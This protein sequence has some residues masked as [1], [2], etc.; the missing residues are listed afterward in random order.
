MENVTF[1]N[2][3]YD[4]GR[5]NISVVNGYD[6]EHGVRNVTFEGLKI[7]GRPIYDDMPDKPKWYATA[8]YVP[9]FVGNHVSGVVFTK[10]IAQFHANQQLS[11]C[12]SLVDRALEALRPQP[13]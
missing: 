11:Y 13:Q 3:R 9:M 4:G 2:V 6:E 10:E 12:S 7:N 1:R 8:D 5:P